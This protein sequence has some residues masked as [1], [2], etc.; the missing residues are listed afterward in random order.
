MREV[1]PEVIASWPE[2]NYVNPES[3]GDSIVIAASI[4]IPIVAV[5]FVCRVYSR[6]FISK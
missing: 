1:P 6:V 5:V 4:C 2:P 3:R